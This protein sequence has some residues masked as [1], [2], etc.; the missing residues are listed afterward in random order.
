[1]GLEGDLVDLT[2]LE[3]GLVDLTYLEGRFGG[4]DVYGGFEVFGR[5]ISWI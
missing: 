5:E 2:Y 3:G 1:M 4:F